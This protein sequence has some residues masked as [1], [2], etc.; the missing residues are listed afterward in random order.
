MLDIKWTC[1]DVSKT[2]RSLFILQGFVSKKEIQKVL[3]WTH[4]VWSLIPR[5]GWRY[6]H[7]DKWEWESVRKKNTYN[8]IRWKNIYKSSHSHL[9]MWSYLHPLLGI[10]DHTTWVHFNTFWISFLETNP[11]KINNDLVVFETSTHVQLM[12]NIYLE[13]INRR[14]KGF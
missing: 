9:F 10:K 12:S 6:D 13:C 5:R 4:V 1:V 14:V 3:K 8:L 7:M 11:C 2:T